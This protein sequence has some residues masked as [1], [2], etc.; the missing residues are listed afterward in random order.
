MGVVDIMNLLPDKGG[1]LTFLMG[2]LPGLFRYDG[3]VLPFIDGKIALNHHV[4]LVAGA[5][6]LLRAPAAIRDLAHVDRVVQHIHHK[7]RRESGHH[8]ILTGDL[9]IAVCVQVFGN[10]SRAAIGMDIFVVDDPD[11][12]SFLLVDEELAVHQHIAIRRKAAVPFAFPCFLLP[13]RH[14]LGADIL[15]FDFRHSRENRDYQLARVL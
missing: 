13:A 3:F 14:G 5:D 6:F 1:F 8:A 9:L 15:P 2:Q 12:L 11:D 7:R 4:H 10:R